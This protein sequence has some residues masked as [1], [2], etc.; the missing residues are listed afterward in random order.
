MDF[1]AIILAVAGIVVGVL[2]TL[3]IKFRA[4]V[5]ADNVQDWKDVVVEEVDSLTDKIEEGK[6]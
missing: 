6:K 4:S 5:K 1:N 2:A 3:Y